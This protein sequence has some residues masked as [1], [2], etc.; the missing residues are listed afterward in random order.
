MFPRFVWL[1]AG[2]CPQEVE[3]RRIGERLVTVEG[4]ALEHAIAANRGVGNSFPSDPALANARFT[5]NEQD[6]A[7][8]IEQRIQGGEL[9]VTADDNRGADRTNWW[10]AAGDLHART[11]TATLS[12]TRLESFR[13]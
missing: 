11:T 6:A 3:Q 13:I 12:R 7:A 1:V 10:H 2:V 9:V 4:G 5:R 8:A